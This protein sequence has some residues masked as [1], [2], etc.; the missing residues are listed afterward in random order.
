KAKT[1]GATHI[2]NAA[3]EDV[4]DRIRE[5]TG[6]MGVDV[7]VEAL[8]RPQTFMQ[9]TLSVKDGGK[10]VMIG[11]SQASSIGEIDINRLVRFRVY[12]NFLSTIKPL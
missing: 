10:D 1:L 7:V 2:V 11:L 5:I 12:L 6:G 9:C 8:G 4:V 3:K